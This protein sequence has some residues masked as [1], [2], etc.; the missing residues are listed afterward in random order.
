MRY[1]DGF[2]EDGITETH[3]K[4]L[5]MYLDGVS[6][7]VLTQ[8]LTNEWFSG[9]VATKHHFDG[10]TRSL[11]RQ[12][13]MPYSK[14]DCIENKGQILTNLNLYLDY[15]RRLK[16]FKD[17]EELRLQKAGYVAM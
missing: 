10:F 11:R 6:N 8:F 17:N 4:F 7:S 3:I 9:T 12:L 1:V 5:K 16:E 15:Q 2:V 13:N 14:K